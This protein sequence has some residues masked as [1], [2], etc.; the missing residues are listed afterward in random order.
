MNLQRRV[1]ITAL[2]VRIYK[3]QSRCFLLMIDVIRLP[4]TVV[5][6][7]AGVSKWATR[8][9]VSQ[10]TRVANEHSNR[11]SVV[12]FELN[13]ADPPTADRKAHLVAMCAV[14]AEEGKRLQTSCSNFKAYGVPGAAVALPV[15]VYAK[16]VVH[17]HALK[18]ESLKKIVHGINSDTY[19][20][21]LLLWIVAP[22]THGEDILGDLNEEY[23][24]RQS[25]EGDVVA[26]AWYRNHELPSGYRAPTVAGD[27]VPL[28][29]C[30]E[31]DSESG[32]HAGVQARSVASGAW[33]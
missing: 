26:R 2:V 32:V 8:R 1:N 12:L 28:E 30:D 27:N 15:I 10:L 21:D 9:R 13:A 24:L 5:V 18:T 7:I 6:A 4:V 31:E 23:L 29:V 33:W 16:G 19:Y 11:T 20:W 17:R 25:K 3:I 14:L 22:G